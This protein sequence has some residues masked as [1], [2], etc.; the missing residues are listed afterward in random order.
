[1]G[2]RFLCPAPRASALRPYRL[3]LSTSFSPKKQGC[4]RPSGLLPLPVNLPLLSTRIPSGFGRGKI[5]VYKK[6][7]FRICEKIFSHMRKFFFVRTEIFFL[8]HG[9]KFSFARSRPSFRREGIF[10]S[11]EKDFSFGRRVVSFRKKIYFL[12]EGKIF[13][14]IRSYRYL[15]SGNNTQSFRR[16]THFVTINNYHHD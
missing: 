7:Y 12:V 4:Q 9:G 16:N 3:P 6:I 8:P 11:E 15:R 5:S 10:S 13:S 1:M 14:S 2:F